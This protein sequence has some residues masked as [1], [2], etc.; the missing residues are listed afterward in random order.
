MSRNA[1]IGTQTAKHFVVIRK[2]RAYPEKV[3]IEWLNENYSY[4]AFITHKD[5]EEPITKEV[6][7]I[8]YH[9]VGICKRKDVRLSTILNELAK[10]LKTDTNGI[11]V[12]K[13]N[14]LDLA[15]QYLIHKNNPEKTPEKPDKIKYNGWT[16]EDI[17]NMLAADSSGINIDRLLTICKTE[18]DFP[19]LLRTLGLHNY[20]K[21]RNVVLDILKYY[22][23]KPII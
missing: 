17:I 8:H 9:Y 18:Q 23:G 3:F 13:Y 14:N 21:Y 15:V 12:D 7:P 11:E 22:H 6:I 19:T 1:P 16:K 5:H 2:N 10:L 4:W 20:H